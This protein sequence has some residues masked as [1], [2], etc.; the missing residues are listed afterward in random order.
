M[1]TAI[2]DFLLSIRTK[3]KKSLRQMAS[4]LNVSPAF[5]SAV[6][7][8]NKKMPDSW[9]K[10]IPNTYELSDDDKE[11]FNDAAYKSLNSVTINL[12]NANESN[13]KFAI[14]FARRFDEIDEQTSDELLELL[15][16]KLKEGSPDE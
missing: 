10:L 2:G 14:K 11:L 1:R 6:E 15:E 9:F 5:L 3:A 16:K 12:A 7:N 4:D 8:G 13:T